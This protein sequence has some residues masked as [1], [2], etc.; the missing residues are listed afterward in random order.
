MKLKTTL[1]V[2][3][4]LLGAGVFA[5]AEEAPKQRPAHPERPISAEVLKEFDQDGDGKLNDQERAAMHAEREKKK[6]ERYDT[7]K[8]GKLSDAEK[9]AMRASRE[10]EMLEKFDAD[11]DGKISDEERKAAQDAGFSGPGGR[12]KRG[13][14]PEGSPPVK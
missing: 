12:H 2:L 13:P 8:D 3:A 6:L 4:S 9:T 14:R 10:K 5:K 1:F 7:D 11:K